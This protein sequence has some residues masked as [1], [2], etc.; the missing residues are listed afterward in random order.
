MKRHMQMQD[1]QP[2]SL[3][4]TGSPETTDVAT[5]NKLRNG[6]EVDVRMEQIQQILGH[7]AMRLLD[8]CALVAEW[9]HHAEAK[10]AVFEQIVAKPKAGRPE[11]A[12]K[13]AARGELPI[14]GKTL[15][16]RCVSTS[17]V[18]SKSTA[19]GKRR[20]SQRELPHST[21]SSAV[22]LP[23]LLSIRWKPNLP[24]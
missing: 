15:V 3:L 24:R 19:S 10:A 12:I 4:V 21:T 17:S 14:P 16:G 22:C 5:S 7:A 23:S 6:D 9:V 18:R 2:H 20:R 13:R 8:R 11:G 1:T